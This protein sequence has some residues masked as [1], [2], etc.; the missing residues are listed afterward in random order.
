MQF[1]AAQVVQV[2]GCARY[3]GPLEVTVTVRQIP[4]V[5]A[6]CGTWG[7]TAGTIE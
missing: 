7:G 5:T 4:L 3:Y 1:R 2:S 6:A